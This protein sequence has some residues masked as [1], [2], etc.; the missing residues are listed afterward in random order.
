MTVIVLLNAV[1]GTVYTSY[2]VITAVELR[3]GWHHL[4]PSPFGIAWVAMA[5]TCGPHHLDHALHLAVDGTGASGAELVA[6]GA[7]LG[8]GLVWFLL[9][10]EAFGGGAGDR[11]IVG[12]PTWLRAATVGVIVASTLSF[13]WVAVGLLATESRPLFERAT[14]NLVLVGLYVV[15]GLYL[16][17]TQVAN[18]SAGGG[19]SLSGVA[20][21]AVFPTCALMHLAFA[22][23]VMTGAT[24]PD[25]HVLV[26]DWLAVPAAVYFLSVVRSLYAGRAHD[27]NQSAPRVLAKAT[28]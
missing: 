10:L 23:T 21:T 3:R 19:W 11:S 24:D 18:R 26:L 27:W 7:G 22:A 17:R 12:T 5:F 2:G 4:G 15:I 6:L 1:V 20:L 25:N 16:G 14:P 9:R 28:T 8:P 13:G